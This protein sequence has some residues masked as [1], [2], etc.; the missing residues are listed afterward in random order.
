MVQQQRKFSL[1]NVTILRK[2]PT[3]FEKNVVLKIKLFR[4]KLTEKESLWFL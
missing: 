4:K 2:I 1:Q 3:E